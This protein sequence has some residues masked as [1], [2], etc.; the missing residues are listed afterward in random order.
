MTG[1]AKAVTR[2]NKYVRLRL[3]QSAEKGCPRTRIEVFGQ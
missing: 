1:Y 3:R 2:L